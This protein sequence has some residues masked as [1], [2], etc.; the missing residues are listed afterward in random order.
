MALQKHTIQK[1]VK[2]MKIRKGDMVEVIAGKDK[3]KRAKVI[4][5][6]PADGKVVLDGLNLVVRHQKRQSTNRATPD[7]QTGRITKPA[8]MPVAKVMLVC[9]HCSKST[10][11]GM[12]VTGDQRVRQC[13]KCREIID[14]V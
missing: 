5:A 13:K 3:D 1:T 14:S 4:Q 8:P 6:I 11:I 7:S 12:T 2:P 10:R 9:P